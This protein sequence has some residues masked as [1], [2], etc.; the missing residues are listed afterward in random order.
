MHSV[1]SSLKSRLVSLS[2]QAL[3]IQKN[4]D[5]QRNFIVFSDPRGGSTWLT[6]L[7]SNI[8][9]TAVIWE[10]LHLEFGAEIFRT[11]HFYW[12]Q[13]IPE[14]VHWVEAHT[15]FEQLF[16]GKYLNRWLCSKSSL[17]SIYHARRLIFKFCRGN[18][19]IPW[20]T[21]QFRFIYKPVYLIRH[22]FAVVASQLRH[23]AWSYQFTRFQLPDVPY[24][25]IYLTH[26][27]Y[28]KQLGTK[29]ELLTAMWCITNLV[30]LRN[31]HNNQKWITVNYENMLLDPER[32]LS[33]IFSQWNVDIPENIST[34]LRKPSATTK[35][36]TFVMGAVPQLQKWQKELTEYQ[37]SNM[38]AVLDYFGVEFYEAQSVLPV[39]SFS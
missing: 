38:A 16:R 24:P 10:P 13:Y 5:P 28:L 36:A 4:Y 29:E 33:R 7:L 15:A 21:N 3:A 39:I 32:E 37:I 8:P 9:Q 31:K 14:D 20:L 19:F 25:Q 23:G 11:L 1:A 26:E 27:E 30:P 6:E 35:E 34:K 17:A 22:P 12:R 2:L 18:A